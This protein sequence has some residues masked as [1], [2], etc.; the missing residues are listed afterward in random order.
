MKKIICW[1]LG[2]NYTSAIYEGQDKPTQKQIDDGLEGFKDYSKMYCKR[3]DHVYK[4]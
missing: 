3:C 2:H 1:L 4:S